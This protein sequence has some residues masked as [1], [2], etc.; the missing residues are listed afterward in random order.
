MEHGQSFLTTQT[1]P[2]PCSR[3]FLQLYLGHRRS[4][5]DKVQYACL[6]IS[7]GCPSLLEGLPAA[8]IS[9]HRG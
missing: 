5:D 9:E 6:R 7:H 4:V 1:S 8:L 3:R 2:A